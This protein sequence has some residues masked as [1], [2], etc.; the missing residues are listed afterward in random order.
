V[1]SGPYLEGVITGQGPRSFELKS[2]GATIG[3]GPDSDLVI[4]QDFAGWDTVSRTHAR[5]YQEGGQWLVQDLDSRNGVWVNGRRTSHNLLRDEW[6]LGIGKVEFV[7]RAGPGE[8][9]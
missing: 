5:V 1:V 8:A 9:K 4:T 7:F 2:E 3:R 6:K